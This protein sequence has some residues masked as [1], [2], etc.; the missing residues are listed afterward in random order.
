MEE[1][2]KEK[3]EKAQ[4]KEKLLKKLSE[5]EEQVEDCYVDIGSLNRDLIEIENKINVLKKIEF[6]KIDKYSALEGFDRKFVIASMFAERLVERQPEANAVYSGEKTLCAASPCYMII[7]TCDIP[8][9][10]Q[11]KAIKWDARRNYFDSIVSGLKWSSELLEGIYKKHSSIC[12]N[13]GKLSDLKFIGPY[14]GSYASMPTI[15]CKIG[16]MGIFFD[17]EYLNLIKKVFTEN[18]DIKYGNKDTDPLIVEEG[19]YKSLLMP[20]K[21]PTFLLEKI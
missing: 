1:L 7:I 13:S 12:Q 8:E 18:A 10:L 9:K 5:L 15:E 11:N 16:D 17:E 21:V 4:E 14:K 3:S 2:L 6:E 20:V 19:D